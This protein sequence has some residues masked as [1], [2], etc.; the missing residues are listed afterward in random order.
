[1][2]EWVSSFFAALILAGVLVAPGCAS[3]ESAWYGCDSGVWRGWE[4]RDE[5]ARINKQ[6]RARHGLV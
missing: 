3:V 5:C 1:M 6:A 2:R 4:Y